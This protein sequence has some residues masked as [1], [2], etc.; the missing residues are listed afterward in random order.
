VNNKLIITIAIILTLLGIFY[1]G[2]IVAEA[3]IVSLGVVTGF[4]IVLHKFPFLLKIVNKMGKWFD[5][6]LFA[7]TF[8]IST[9]PFGFMMATFISLYFSA[10]LSI[11]S[12][13]TKKKVKEV[14]T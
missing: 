3:S 6:L 11:L 9:T 5:M 1:T 10:Y 7:I 14:T 12:Y 4:A 13:F 2:V 8:G